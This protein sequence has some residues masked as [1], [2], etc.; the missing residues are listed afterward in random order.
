MFKFQTSDLDVGEELFI[1]SKYDSP[2]FLR[3]HH[4]TKNNF[5]FL[6]SCSFICFL[7]IL[8]DQLFFVYF[9][10]LAR[11]QITVLFATGL[12]ASNSNPCETLDLYVNNG[13]FIIVLAIGIEPNIFQCFIDVGFPVYYYPTV[14]D[15]D[16][17]LSVVIEN[18]L[19]SQFFFVPP[20]L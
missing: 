12:W 20:P 6:Q 4:L 19:V 7:Q 18:T 16:D 8:I 15:T 9:C 17:S 10:C 13:I 11:A 2:R 5:K 1:D 3:L 14:Y